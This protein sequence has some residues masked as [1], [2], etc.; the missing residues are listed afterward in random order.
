VI[1]P[2]L[3]DFLFSTLERDF[4]AELFIPATLFLLGLVS[5]QSSS[6]IEDEKEY[7]DEGANASKR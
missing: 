7:V 6:I 1:S 5:R 2:C 4:I 3:T